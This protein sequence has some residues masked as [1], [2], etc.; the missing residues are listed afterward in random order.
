MG[1]KLDA[2]IR[3]ESKLRKGG[4]ICGRDKFE[5]RQ[6]PSV[7]T[8][9]FAYHVRSIPQDI[10]YLFN[11]LLIK[12]TTQSTSG[13]IHVLEGSAGM[14]HSVRD[15]LG[16]L[17]DQVAG[18]IGSERQSS[19]AL[20]L[21]KVA[22]TPLLEILSQFELHCMH[23]TTACNADSLR[24]L[25]MFWRHVVRSIDHVT[26]QIDKLAFEHGFVMYDDC[27][28]CHP[29]DWPFDRFPSVANLHEDGDLKDIPRVA[30]PLFDKTKR[31][32]GNRRELK[33]DQYPKTYSDIASSAI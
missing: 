22:E 23:T 19:F 26:N 33:L 21:R 30:V 31:P 12:K 15:D 14:L 10:L 32:R 24:D 18:S 13:P 20:T 7:Q 3:L 6:Y 2:L 28:C 8:L 27:F 9:A 5:P 1:R 25:A 17:W 4:L 29:D 16:H 11:R